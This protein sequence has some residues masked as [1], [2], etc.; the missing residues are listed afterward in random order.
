MARRDWICALILGNLS[1]SALP[2][3]MPG[4]AEEVLLEVNVNGEKQENWALVMTVDGLPWVRCEDLRSWGVQLAPESPAARLPRD[5]LLPLNTVPGV[6]ASIDAAGS[7]LM[8][9]VQPALLRAHRFH[10]ESATPQPLPSPWTAFANYDIGGS[11]AG[12]AND[13]RVLTELGVAQGNWVARSSWF[14]TSDNLRTAAPRLDTNITL[15]FPATR[16][17][18]QLG[19]AFAALGPNAEPVRVAGFSLATDFSLTPTFIT[20]PLPSVNSLTATASTVDLF[21]NGSKTQQFTV[22]AGPYSISGVPVTTG[23]GELT[24]VPHDLCGHTESFTQSYYIAPQMLAAGLSAWEFQAGAKRQNYGFAGDQYSGW[25]ADIGE[26]VG[27]SERL[28]ALWRIEADD[29]GS[30]ASAQWLILAPHNQLVTISPTC[31]VAFSEVG[32]SL[33]TGVE[34]TLS[35]FGY[36]VDAE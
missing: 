3:S 19:D 14:A 5:A 24:I 16:L 35:T 33:A 30:G 27:V 1:S 18:L 25:L 31:D 28:T 6:H 26:R 22:P 32:C 29:T 8:V 15:D 36:G 34:H 21:V 12:D 2:A 13:G 7:R 20:V 23:P 10:S 4:G 9:D 17:S 11:R